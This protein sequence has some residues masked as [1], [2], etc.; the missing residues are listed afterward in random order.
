MATILEVQNVS[1]QFNGKTVLDNTSF[2]IAANEIIALVGKNG[3]GKS[4]LLKIIAAFIKPDSGKIVTHKTSLK[5]GYVPEV[6]PSHILFTPQE[7]LY[8]MGRIRG[9]TKKHLLQK[10]KELLEMFQLKE[11]QNTRIVHFSKGMRQKVMIM[12]AML[13]ETDLLIMDEPLSGLDAKAQ[14]DFEQILA[15]V[16]DKGL[17]II[18][19]CHE[20]KLLEN[21][22]DSVLLIQENQ[23][24]H[25]KD[26]DSHPVH[27]LIFDIASLALLDEILPLM[28][29]QQKQPLA[30]GHFEIITI[31]QAKDSDQILLKLLQ[32]N[33]S[34]K[35]L[36]N[37]HHKKEEFSSHF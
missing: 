26:L 12:Q 15:T 14:N 25:T 8:H 4:T 33:A 23:I 10:I 36:A 28:E 27:R 9:M 21:L 30:N 1:K 5:V 11:S 34:I 35:Y 37:V 20:T 16:R 29:I 19:T 7:Y 3:S 2:S 18:L 24:I 6:T 32:K 13:E 22:V 31:V 17:S